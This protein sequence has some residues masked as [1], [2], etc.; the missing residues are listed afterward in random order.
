MADV[1]MYNLQPSPNNM[2]VRIA[3]NYKG[4]P[5]DRVEITPDNQERAEVVAA[6]GQPLTPVIKHGDRAVS[7]SSAIVR[8]LEANFPDTPKLLFTE[9]PAMMEAERLERWIRTYINEPVGMVFNQAIS[10]TP[11][12]EV[13]A[14]AT[15]LMQERT[16]ELEGRLEG[17]DWLLGDRMTFVDVTAAPFVSYSMVPAEMAAHHPIVQFFHDHFQLGDGRDRTRAWCG[18]VMSYD[19]APQAMEA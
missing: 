19:R 12:L 2:K 11:D 4:I 13:C 6:S 10:E 14:E 17:S 1:L 7:D 9:R 8:Y 16:G 18:R 5:F 15:R 3:L